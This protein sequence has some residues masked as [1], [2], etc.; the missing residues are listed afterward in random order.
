[1]IGVRPWT[2]CRSD[3]TASWSCWAAAAWLNL[4]RPGRRCTGRRAGIAVAARLAVLTHEIGSPWRFEF[5]PSHD[6]TF[7]IIGSGSGHLLMPDPTQ[8]NTTTPYRSARVTSSCFRTGTRTPDLSVRRQRPQH[9]HAL[10]SV[11]TRSGIALVAAAVAADA[12]QRASKV[13][14]DYRGLGGVLVG[15]GSPRGCAMRPCVGLRRGNPHLSLCPK[16]L[17]LRTPDAGQHRFR[18]FLSHWPCRHRG[19]TPTSVIGDRR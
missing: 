10:R 15:F 11:S 4:A 7:H 12:A 18:C 17:G 19:V 14:V 13:S 2:R 9:R 1:V 5:T 3:A 16:H 8:R 6:S